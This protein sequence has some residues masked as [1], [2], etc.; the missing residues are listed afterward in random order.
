MADDPVLIAKERKA[1]MKLLDD[2][3]SPFKVPSRKLN[4][5]LIVATWNIRQFSNNK[6]KRALQYIAD[7]CE[8]F[9]I[10]ALQEVKTD[11]RG[12]DGLLKLLPGNY[13]FLV[14]DPT[15]NH[16]RFAFLYDKRSVIN[17]GLVCEIGFNVPAGTHQGFQLHRMPYCASFRAGRFDFVM[18][19]V[20]IFFGSSAAELAHREE[21]IKQLIQFIDRR[22][23][24][25]S[26]KVFDQD[27]FVVGDFNI[28]DVADRFFKALKSKKFSTP[29]GK[30]DLKTN[31]ARTRT[32]D[33][34]AWVNRP[35]FAPTGACNVVPFGKVLFQDKSPKGGAK[36]I[37]D[38]LPLWA[39]FEINK[40]SQK[41]DQIIQRRDD[42]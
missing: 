13:K 9:D 26:N 39:E 15:G 10:I 18:A 3:D 32:F 42:D 41:L 1:L 7:I 8:R 30:D 2:A 27:F 23:K 4:E 20:H 35:S 12:L 34:I 36:E 24:T 29:A 19:S 37:S 17:T 31:F 33:K 25:D 38:H 16:E 5:N 21:E 22:S 11:L 28:E 40:L 14:S 6:T